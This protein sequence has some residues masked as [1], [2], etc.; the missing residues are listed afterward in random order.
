MKDEMML[1]VQKINSEFYITFENLSIE[2]MEGL[3]KHL[4]TEQLCFMVI[5]ANR[6]LP[7]IFRYLKPFGCKA[8]YKNSCD[9]KNPFSIR[10][11]KKTGAKIVPPR[12]YK[13]FVEHPHELKE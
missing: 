12:L 5:L 6:L 11:A 13:Y 3:W 2:R 4:L 1:Q 8:N 10:T 7:R 9:S